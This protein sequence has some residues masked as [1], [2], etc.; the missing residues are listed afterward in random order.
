MITGLMM[1]LCRHAHVRS[2]STI[3]LD[4]SVLVTFESFDLLAILNVYYSGLG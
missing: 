3:A 2:V 1:V 4:L